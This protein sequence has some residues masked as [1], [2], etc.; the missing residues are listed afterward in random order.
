VKFHF[1]IV[2]DLGTFIEVEAIDTEDK[3]TIEELRE[4]CNKYYHF[5]GFTESN[6]IDK[7]YSDLIIALKT[8]NNR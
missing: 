6:N 7:S 5:F 4:Q 1:D 8:Q 3:F 2:E